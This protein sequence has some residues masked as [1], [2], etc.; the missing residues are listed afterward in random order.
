MEAIDRNRVDK[1]LEFYKEYREKEVDRDNIEGNFIRLNEDYIKNGAKN[2][3]DTGKNLYT[4]IFSD[5]L[6]NKEVLDSILSSAY[7]YNS[8]SACAVNNVC[9]QNLSCKLMARSMRNFYSNFGGFFDKY[10]NEWY[11][12]ITPDV[13]VF[14]QSSSCADVL[15]VQKY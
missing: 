13:N 3:S 9:D 5:E 14:L 10:K 15:K 7:F 4:L 1:T 11:D 12:N 8:V 2:E 6:K